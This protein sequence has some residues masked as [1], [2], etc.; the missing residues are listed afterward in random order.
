MCFP[1]AAG[2]PVPLFG[3]G[4]GKPFFHFPQFGLYVQ[5]EASQQKPTNQPIIVETST[6]VATPRGDP[7]TRPTTMLSRA[8]E[9]VLYPESPTLPGYTTWPPT[10]T[11]PVRPTLQ[12]QFQSMTSSSPMSVSQPVSALS[13]EYSSSSPSEPSFTVNSR[14][15]S[16]PTS[17]AI[18]RLTTVADVPVA[19]EPED[20]KPLLLQPSMPNEPDNVLLPDERRPEESL[21][22]TPGMTPLKPA[23]NNVSDM[24]VAVQPTWTSRAT[25]S[26]GPDANQTIHKVDLPPIVS[27][28][29]DMLKWLVIAV[30]A[31]V[32]LVI[33]CVFVICLRSVDNRNNKKLRDFCKYL[34][35]VA[36]ICAQDI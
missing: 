26:A 10:V 32:V 1:A 12:D 4:R 28:E 16:F 9:V 30:A 18:E 33:V 6:T 21:L 36:C 2:P 25:T 24:P 29:T 35:F 23:Q 7:A 31:A 19:T 20:S 17:S 15:L 22:I 34:P 8:T 27:T 14:A 13:T 3:D 5:P 11:D